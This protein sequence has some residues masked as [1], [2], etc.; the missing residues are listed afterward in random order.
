MGVRAL[1]RK[2]GSKKVKKPQEGKYRGVRRRPW[3]RYAAEI[4]DPH[5]RERRWLGTFDTAEQAAVAYDLAARS[6]RGLKARTN[7][8]YPTHQTCLMSAALAASRASG[9]SKGEGFFGG[10]HGGKSGRNLDW[11]MTLMPDGKNDGAALSSR[12]FM[13]GSMDTLLDPSSEPAFRHMYETVERLASAISDPRPRKSLHEDGDLLNQHACGKVTDVRRSSGRRDQW[14]VLD[15]RESALSQS[16]E[17]NTGGKSVLCEGRECAIVEVSHP[18]VTC[19]GSQ[20]SF[21]HEISASNESS[22]TESGGPLRSRES[23]QISRASSSSKF[24]EHGPGTLSQVVSKYVTV[25]KETLTVSS[26]SPDNRLVDSSQC[27]LSTQV[28][29]SEDSSSNLVVSSYIDTATSPD[30]ARFIPSSVE[31]SE[32]GSAAGV[33]FCNTSSSNRNPDN[34]QSILPPNVSSAMHNAPRPVYAQPCLDEPRPGLT[35]NATWSDVTHD[36]AESWRN[37]CEPP[38]AW[39]YYTDPG[40]VANDMEDEL[41][42]VT[43]ELAM[44]TSTACQGTQDGG[45]GECFMSGDWLFPHCDAADSSFSC[46]SDISGDEYLCNDGYS[47]AGVHVSSLLHHAFYDAHQSLPVLL[48]ASM[49]YNALGM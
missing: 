18:E 6:M 30:S 41:V 42:D 8:V 3:G 12:N 31:S 22:L 17:Q 28:S 13:L 39:Q 38:A 43:R 45:C 37:L 23:G 49:D 16:L 1:E 47:S 4:R 2:G 25:D 20:P 33:T 35:Q 40:M 15:V 9:Q 14:A 27:F 32:P 19:I 11:S 48:E 24:Y 5:T 10:V 44:R 26:S 46:M 21:Y 36:R 34:L 7:F 29:Y